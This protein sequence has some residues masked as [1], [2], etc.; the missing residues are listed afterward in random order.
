MDWGVKTLPLGTIGMLKDNEFIHSDLKSLAVNL[1]R[2]KQQTE[3]EL[4]LNK[5]NT[6]VWTVV[7]KVAQGETLSGPNYS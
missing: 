2:Q 1:E 4:K 7:V 3:L 5:R 6:V